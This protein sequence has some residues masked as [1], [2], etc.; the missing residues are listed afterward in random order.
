MITNYTFSKSTLHS[1]KK[2]IITGSK[3][4]TNRLLILQAL[5][6]GVTISNGSTSDDTKIIQY[7]LHTKNKVINVAHAGTAMRFLTAYFAQKKGTTVVLTGSSRM[8]ERPIGILVTAL[9]QLGADISY[10]EKENYPPLKINGKKLNKTNCIE[11]PANISSQYVSAL[12][13][14]APT[15]TNGLQLKLIGKTTSLPYIKMTLA[16]LKKATITTLFTNN[17]ITISPKKNIIPVSFKVTSDWSSAS[18]YYSLIA[19]SK[20]TTTIRLYNYTKN[21]LQGD[22]IVSKLYENFGVATIFNSDSSITITKKQKHTISTFNHNLEN[23][24]DIAQTIAVTCLGLN[25]GCK[26]TG[27]HTLKIKETDRLLA[28]QNEITKLGAEVTLSPNSLSFKPVETIQPN[29]SITTYN[30]HRMAMAFI[31]LA[32][33]VPVTIE[34]VSVVSKSYPNFWKDMAFIG[35]QALP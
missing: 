29:C 16:L 2:C 21:S 15:L 10:L 33:K 6:L 3:S 30:D 28:L 20:I 14:I 9:R 18:Y 34:N 19:L 22:S 24:P 25:I 11:L 4:E 31:P 13:L 1:G 17:I 12:L 23:Y 26:L 27:L 5:Y 7:A 8:K 35:I 32:L